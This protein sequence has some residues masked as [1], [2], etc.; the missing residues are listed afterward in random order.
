MLLFILSNDRW[1]HKMNWRHFHI[2]KS[3]STKTGGNWKIAYIPREKTN[4]TAATTTTKTLWDERKQQKLQ[5]HIA[6]TRKN[7]ENKSKIKKKKIYSSHAPCVQWQWHFNLNSLLLFSTSSEL[8]GL[9]L[10]SFV[11]SFIVDYEFIDFFF[12]VSFI[13]HITLISSSRFFLK[14]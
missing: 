12:S 9:L 2:V 11:N 7:L 3:F 5:L 10:F 4:Q 1:C 14:R 13:N 6:I 8:S